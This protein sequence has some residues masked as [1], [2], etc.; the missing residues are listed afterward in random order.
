MWDR[1]FV[2]F[3]CVI[4]AT[5]LCHLLCVSVQRASV[6]PVTEQTTVP[7]PQDDRGLTR[8]H[9]LLCGGE[10]VPQG[11]GLPFGAQVLNKFKSVWLK[12]LRN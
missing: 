7:D 4:T 8:A 10:L 6:P 1:P 11:G 3:D 9:Q 2:P 5:Q 12:T